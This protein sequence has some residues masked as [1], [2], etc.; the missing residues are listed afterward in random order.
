M[1][2]TK[3]VLFMTGTRADF[4]KIK[5]LISILDKHADFDVHVFV[6]GMHMNEKF[7]GTV[8][9][10]VNCG[11]K[12]V[13][14]YDNGADTGNYNYILAKTVSGFSDCVDEIKPDIIVIHGDRIEALAGAIVGALSNVLVCHIEGGEV[15]GTVDEHIRHSISKLAHI[16]FVANLTAKKRLIQMGE[17]KNNIFIIGSP[18]LDVMLSSNLPS[19]L[20]IKKRYEIPFDDY[21]VVLYHPVVTEIDEMPK[22]ISIFVD[23]LISSG[24]NYVVIYPNNDLGNKLILDTYKNKLENN[25]HFNIL[26][27]MRFEF[28]LSLIKNAKFI[29]GNSSVGIHEAPFYGV[30]SIDVGSRQNNRLDGKRVASVTHVDYIKKDLLNSINKFFNKQVRY[31]PTNHFGK[32]DSA[33]RFLKIILKKSF[34][35][36]KIQKRFID[37]E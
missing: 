11:F 37:I 22:Q 32:G 31:K 24:K 7:G 19:L 4:G 35:S 16:H 30:P 8:Y 1:K 23:T 26:P 15:S 18:D 17:N 34:W 14:K 9:E 13:F 12:S 33:E 29:I 36:I 6:T 25:P 5:G 28:F 21:G 27:S 3:K 2:K 10:V 20:D